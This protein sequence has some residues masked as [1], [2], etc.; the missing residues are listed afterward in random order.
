MSL[1]KEQ[2]DCM[3]SDE[4]NADI[5]FMRMSRL[6]VVTTRHVSMLCFQSSYS[7]S[8]IKYKCRKFAQF[9]RR[10]GVCEANASVFDQ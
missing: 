10:A 5:T 9:L 2:I 1:L 3:R 7:I 8:L 4:T 6:I